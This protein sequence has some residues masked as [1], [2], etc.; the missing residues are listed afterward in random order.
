MPR[1]APVPKTRSIHSPVLSFQTYAIPSV[2]E[3]EYAYTCESALY[4]HCAV[5]FESDS[6]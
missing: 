3:Y 4:I 2:C 5:K 1:V 6:I